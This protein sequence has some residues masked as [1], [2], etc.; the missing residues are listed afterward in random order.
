M[1]KTNKRWFVVLGSV[2]NVYFTDGYENI[3]Q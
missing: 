2:E 3:D 1:N